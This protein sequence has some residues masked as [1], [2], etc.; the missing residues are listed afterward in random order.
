V[1]WLEDTDYNAKC[2]FQGYDEG[3]TISY[4]MAMGPNKN[5]FSGTKFR[6]DFEG[7]GYTLNASAPVKVM[8]T[9]IKK[10]KFKNALTHKYTLNY[11]FGDDFDD[12]E[13]WLNIF[14]TNKTD[15][16]LYDRWTFPNFLA[17]DKFYYDNNTKILLNTPNVTVGKTSM[18]QT[19]YDLKLFREIEKGK[20]VGTKVI[21]VPVVYKDVI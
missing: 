21:G 19:Y 4:L 11:L 18:K 7:Q 9:G 14:Y 16:E 10:M 12:I 3:I 6:K 1:W 17:M 8:E 5:T 2:V 15:S 13:V 20:V